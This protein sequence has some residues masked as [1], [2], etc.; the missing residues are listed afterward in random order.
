MPCA[1]FSNRNQVTQCLNFEI[2]CTWTVFWQLCPKSDTYSGLPESMAHI[3]WSLHFLLF[4]KI[5][6]ILHRSSSLY[7]GT[8]TESSFVGGSCILGT[9]SFRPSAF[10]KNFSSSC[11]WRVGIF[12]AVT[13]AIIITCDEKEKRKIAEHSNKGLPS[14]R[15]CY[16]AQSS[17]FQ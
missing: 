8:T 14:C 11:R 6:K 3:K 7:E 17:I 1:I 16:K 2:Q 12:T 4:P 9:A 15:M 10:M 13:W 5:R